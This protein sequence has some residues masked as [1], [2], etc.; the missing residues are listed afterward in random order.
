VILFPHSLSVKANLSFD[1]MSLERRASEAHIEDV[2]EFILLSSITEAESNRS[3]TDNEGRI[4]V[5]ICILNRVNDDRFPDTISGV[6]SQSGQFS[7]CRRHSDGTY[8]SVTERTDLSDQAVIE[9]VRRIES[10]EAPAV[11]WFNCIGY[12]YG[13]P[14]GNIGGNYFSC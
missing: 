5:A 10:G 12:S 8:Y 9:A 2:D 1:D 4:M 14:Y 13:T 6:I 7:T 11:L 3:Q